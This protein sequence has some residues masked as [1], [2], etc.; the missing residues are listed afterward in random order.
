MKPKAIL[1]TAFLMVAVVVAIIIAWIIWR[2]DV[3]GM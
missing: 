3:T 2:P 1:V